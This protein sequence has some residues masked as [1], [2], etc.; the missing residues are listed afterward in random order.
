MTFFFLADF[1]SFLT[2][3]KIGPGAFN[4][5]GMR[6]AADRIAVRLQELAIGKDEDMKQIGN[7]EEQQSTKEKAKQ[8]KPPST[9][10][11]SQYTHFAY[12]HLPQEVEA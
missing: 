8:S 10:S 9:E 5:E 11:I 7:E 3:V 4:L 2:F 12:N 6:A 1:F